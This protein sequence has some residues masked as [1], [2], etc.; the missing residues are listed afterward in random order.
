MNNIDEPS[1]KLD[2]SSDS[3][4]VN[5]TEKSTSTEKNI[6]IE[7]EIS[8]ELYIEPALSKPNITNNLKSETT[9]IIK[10]YPNKFIKFVDE[11][12]FVIS[13]LIGCFYMISCFWVFIYFIYESSPIATLLFFIYIFIFLSYIILYLSMTIKY[14]DI[15]YFLSIILGLLIGL[16]TCGGGLMF[17]IGVSSFI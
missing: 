8:K 3:N 14:K 2:N 17:F 1:N 4:I 15:K 11:H 16:F 5:D 10:T 9:N 7:N 13:A 12:Y 6:N